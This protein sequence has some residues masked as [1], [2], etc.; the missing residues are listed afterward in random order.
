MERIEITDLMHWN[1]AAAVMLALGALASNPAAAQSAGGGT[2]CSGSADEPCPN[3]LSLP[4]EGAPTGGTGGLARLCDCACG[5]GWWSRTTERAMLFPLRPNWGDTQTQRFN[6]A[7][8][9]GVLFSQCGHGFGHLRLRLGEIVQL[10]LGGYPSVL[11]LPQTGH[12]LASQVHILACVGRRLRFLTVHQFARG[13][14]HM[15][16]VFNHVA[17]R[18]DFKRRQPSHRHGM[19]LLNVQETRSPTIHNL[20]LHPPNASNQCTPDLQVF[21]IAK[22]LICLNKRDRVNT[23]CSQGPPQ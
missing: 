9:L 12:R 2:P 18:Y 10:N 8:Q 20:A 13:F 17:P 6:C 11:Q 16:C 5:T 3:L 1:T 7:D 19:F 15:G 14:E 23:S 22:T 21:P 4:C